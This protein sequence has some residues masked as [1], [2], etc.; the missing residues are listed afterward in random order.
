MDRQSEQSYRVNATQHIEIVGE[1]LVPLLLQNQ[2]APMYEN[3][4]AIVKKNKD[5]IAL[6][7]FNE[8]GKRIYPF[9]K[10]PVKS[11]AF[12]GSLSHTIKIRDRNLGKIVLALDFEST[13]KKF[14]AQN[15]RLVGS[16]F[17]TLTGILIF[18]AFLA[19]TLIG[20]PA[21]VL[22]LAADQLAKGDFNASL[23]PE[24]NDEIGILVKSFSTMRDR[25]E[26]QQAALVKRELETRM[27]HQITHTARES[28]SIENSIRHCLGMICE[29]TD[30]ILGHAYL[31]DEKNPST[32]VSTQI[33]H[34]PDNLKYREFINLTSK[35]DLAEGRGLPEKAMKS[36]KMELISDISADSEILMERSGSTKDLKAA[37]ALPI[38]VN[39]ECVAV[40][41]FFTPED[42][43]SDEWFFSLL[44]EIGAQ[45]GRVLERKDAEA[46]LKANRDALK[47]YSEETKRLSDMNA[48]E[49]KKAEA[50]AQAKTEFLANMS[51][52]IRSPMNAILGFSSLALQT[53]L[54]PKQKDFVSKIDSSGQ[55]LLTVINDIL[56]FS[57]IEA[58]EMEYADSPFNPR[59]TISQTIDIFSPMVAGK[60]LL[61]KQSISPEVPNGLW[62]DPMRVKQILIN[63]IGNAIKF[64]DKGQ[65]EVGVLVNHIA[66]NY[67]V[68][69]FAVRDTGCGIPEDKQST[70]FDPFTQIDGSLTR[71]QGGTGLG[72]AI[73]KKL[74]DGMGGK[75]N[76]ESEPGKGS[77]FRFS[78]K[79]RIADQTAINDAAPQAQFEQGVGETEIDLS[80][81]RVLLV[82]DDEINQQIAVA[83]LTGAGITVETAS[84][85]LQA[86]EILNE[87]PTGFDIVL[88]DIQ[89]PV[90]DGVAATKEIRKKW[91]SK[92]L[93]IIALTAHAFEE[94][95]QRCLKAGMDDH[96]TKPISR[97][98]LLKAINRQIKAGGG[99][100][101]KITK[102]EPSAALEKAT[103]IPDIPG[104]DMP[105]MIAGFN[106]N[107]SLLLKLI[108][109]FADRYANTG[110]DL[111]RLLEKGEIKQAEI[112]VHKVA[113]AAGNLG[114][115][116]IFDTGRA[117]EIPL[118]KEDLDNW[119]DH[120]LAF[121][122]SLA[123]TVEGAKAAGLTTTE[124]K[125][126]SDESEGHPAINQSEL[127]TLLFELDFLLTSN[128]LEAKRKAE[129]LAKKSVGVENVQQ[130]LCELIDLIEGLDFSSAHKSLNK[131]AQVLNAPEKVCVNG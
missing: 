68:M 50:A 56:D 42:T 41:E 49:R 45:L 84:D 96:I 71:S 92:N 20:K 47:I 64:T 76:M 52:E 120:V 85:G 87:N 109:S 119:Q 126:P 130:P 4:D 121:E 107:H 37:V 60:G 99:G 36:K 105:K 22:A 30:W 94:E 82:E 123:A 95:R 65:I 25:L 117:I 67:A 115:M 12:I 57:K 127:E 5:W 61:L 19:D 86:I 63:L 15:Y 34:G 102:P 10:P 43:T 32:L 40:I 81:R 66:D 39:D 54:T 13:I 112:L 93:P 18:A 53:D 9:V 101:L 129:E 114:A 23:P 11:G 38:I 128:N 90:M 62:G 89:M 26:T 3:L 33:W 125:S 31:I 116:G 69:E 106:G 21:R 70:L 2:Y 7:V 46:K 55:H 75:I 44:S 113:G 80:E 124:Q 104:I 28:N 77:I 100:P 98:K 131:L 88:M 48:R 51:H 108:G 29:E 58:G 35:M 122:K 72:L 14:R 110:H 17:F 24:G 83:F 91:P 103:S 111:R 8:D 73:S 97:E 1:L 79:L 74:V 27:I 118:S 6:E 16:L 78:I 59:E